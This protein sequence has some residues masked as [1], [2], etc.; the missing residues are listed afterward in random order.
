[1]IKYEQLKPYL[2]TGPCIGVG[3]EWELILLP[4]YMLC[5]IY[6]K[7]TLDPNYPDEPYALF[8][9]SISPIWIDSL[10]KHEYLPHQET[11]NILG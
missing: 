5:P 4:I 10:I 3:F 1:M 9:S 11:M 8:I 7:L 2:W 6:L